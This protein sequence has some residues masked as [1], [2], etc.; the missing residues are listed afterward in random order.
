VRFGDFVELYDCASA[1]GSF[2]AFLT[3]FALDTASNIFRYVR[4]AAHVVREGGIW[5]NFGSLAYDA[6]H[7][8]AHG[9][10][11]E[12][13]WEE[14]KYAVSHFFDVKEEAYVDPSMR[15]TPSP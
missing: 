9:R 7:D 1:R 10:G 3:A 8:E 4:T 2:D 13:S 12:L 15:R 11:V 6:D 14:L 5:A